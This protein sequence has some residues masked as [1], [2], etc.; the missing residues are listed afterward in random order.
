MKNL[1]LPTLSALL[2]VLAFPPWDL[3]PLAFVAL[4]PFILS[5]V[6]EPRPRRRFFLAA[7]LSLWVGVGGFYWMAYSAHEFGGLPWVA[8]ILILIAYGLT[9]HPVFY[10]YALI[11]SYARFPTSWKGALGLAFAY[12]AWDFWIPKLFRDTLGHA[13]LP[14]PHLRQAA[15]LGTALLLTFIAVVVNE[16]LATCWMERHRLKEKRWQGVVTLALVFLLSAEAYGIWKKRVVQEWM[17]ESSTSLRIAVAQGN[18]G[19]IDKIASETGNFIAKEKV[20]RT[21]LELSFEAGATSPQPDVVVWPE[22]AYPSLFHRP[23]DA[24]D[25]LNEAKIEEL[26]AKYRFA[27]LF[28]GYDRESS[29][30]FNTLFALTSDGGVLGNRLQL[31]HKGLL[32]PFAEFIPIVGD[33]LWVERM[34]PQIGNFGRGTGPAILSVPITLKTGETLQWRIAP[35]IC[36]EA[37]FPTYTL[38]T[39]RRGSQAILNVTNDSWFGPWAEPHLHLAQTAFRSIETR[40]P[41]IRATNT[42]IS[43]LILPDGEMKGLSSIGK[44]G[45]F[46]YDVPV[47][48]DHSARSLLYSWGDWFGI[49]STLITMILGVRI[50]RHRKIFT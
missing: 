17:K 12:C 22:T 15:D 39:A 23:L 46:Y 31:Y 28:G 33:M 44:P 4:V 38:D 13:F 41:Q 2:Y 42:G 10:I 29:K 37:L 25:Q 47:L 30:D 1:W 7:W 32:L 40:L 20:V 43:A 6:R 5:L 50:F 45:V 14:L 49:F 8:C 21:Y 27:L 26:V 19:D 3:A 9:A 34:F 35:I 18:I 11:R 36:Y 16:A 48:K 24:G